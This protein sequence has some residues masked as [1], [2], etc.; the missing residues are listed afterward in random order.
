[1]R[2]WAETP[3]LV[4]ECNVIRDWDGTWDGKR[5]YR[6]RG[7]SRFPPYNW[8]GIRTTKVAASG[9]KLLDQA[10]RSIAIGS[11]SRSQ[12]LNTD[13]F[14]DLAFKTLKVQRHEIFGLWFFHQ[15]IIPRP[16]MNTLK[17]FRIMFRIRWEIDENVL[18]RAM[19]HS[20]GPWS[21]AMQHSAGPWSCAMKHSVGSKW[22]S[23]GSKG[24]TLAQCC[25][26]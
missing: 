20:A 17:Y 23:A 6:R 22:H 1:M 8:N 16:R 21:R 10:K 11:W 13:T 15:S 12:I 24:Q 14:V 18:I 2:F 19:P 7:Q 4:Q 9:L 5:G 26:A 25:I 3:P